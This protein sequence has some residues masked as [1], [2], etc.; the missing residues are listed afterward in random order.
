[1]WTYLETFWWKNHF[2]W[3]F[4]TFFVHQSYKGEGFSGF[5]VTAG[6]FPAAASRSFLTAIPGVATRWWQ[7]DPRPGEAASGWFK[8]TFFF[9]LRLKV[10]PR[11]MAGREIPPKCCFFWF[12]L[13]IILKGTNFFFEDFFGSWSIGNP[14]FSAVFLS[15]FR[16]KNSIFVFWVYKPL[17]EII[18]VW[19]HAVQ[20]ALKKLG[21]CVFGILGPQKKPAGF[22]LVS[23]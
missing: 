11:K 9:G 12:N 8:Q 10:S 5:F 13:E 6:G 4:P 7:R 20:L 1:M 2:P 16:A 22:Y 3:F 18:L 21:C 17:D 19:N 14:L 23:L 15:A